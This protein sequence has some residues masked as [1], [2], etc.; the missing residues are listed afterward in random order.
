M[1]QAPNREIRQ[2]NQQTAAKKEQA[3]KDDS[4]YTQRAA[5]AEVQENSAETL[6]QTTYQLLAI[7]RWTLYRK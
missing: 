7:Y 2:H 3:R 4:D 1:I 6:K 5:E